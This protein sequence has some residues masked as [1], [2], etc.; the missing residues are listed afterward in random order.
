MRTFLAAIMAVFLLGACTPGAHYVSQLEWNGGGPLGGNEPDV[1]RPAPDVPIIG[2]PVPPTMPPVAPEPPVAPP[3]D[4]PVLPPVDP[5]TP[6]VV[7]PVE[8][9]DP[10]AG[11]RIK[12]LPP[13][14]A[15]ARIIK[16]PGQPAIVI[17]RP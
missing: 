2:R 4:P 16:C 17:K 15:V 10:Y 9:P 11:C 8:P 12:D 1:V 7:P 14:S 6:P 3:V 13:P 5:P